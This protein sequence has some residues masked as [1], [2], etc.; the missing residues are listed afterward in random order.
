MNSDKINFLIKYEIPL[1]D[2][3]FQSC[4]IINNG[5]IFII[6]ITESK[7]ILVGKVL[8]NDM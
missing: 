2:E 3:I 8:D 7:I 4:V 1:F 5:I 6:I